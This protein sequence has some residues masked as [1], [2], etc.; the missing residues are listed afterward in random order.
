MNKKHLSDRE[1]DV[2]Q[3]LW[4]SPKPMLASEILSASSDLNI[5]TVQSTLRKLLSREYVCVA[6]ILQTG[7]GLGR[8]FR[9]VLTADEYILSEFERILPANAERRAK[10]FAAFIENCDDKEKCLCELEQII[11]D[12]R[13]GLT[14]N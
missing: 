14:G 13:N 10:L 3:I 6:E 1:F 4:N 2:M 11:K 9:P 8:T 12:C 7:K 5:N